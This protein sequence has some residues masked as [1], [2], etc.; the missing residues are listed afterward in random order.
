MAEIEI[1]T[2]LLAI[3]SLAINAILVPLILKCNHEVKKIA[4]Q[5]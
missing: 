3:I 5:S 4:P 2:N 1:G